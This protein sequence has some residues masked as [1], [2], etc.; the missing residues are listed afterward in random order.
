MNGKAALD[1]NAIVNV[2]NN[3]LDL[4]RMGVREAY[5]PIVAIGELLYGVHKSARAAENRARLNEYLQEVIVLDCT[6]ETAD[7][8]GRIK[9]ALRRAGTPIPE[10]DKW[11]AAAALEHQLPIVTNDKHFENVAGLEIIRY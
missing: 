5:V 4:S 6:M 1:S 9:L 2:L 10:N 8:Y 3:R 7:L 11:I